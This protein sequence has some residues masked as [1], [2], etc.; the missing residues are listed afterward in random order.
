VTVLLGLLALLLGVWT[1][2]AVRLRRA[3]RAV[4][5]RIHVNG[6]RGK[7]SVTRLI[8]GGLQE[9]GIP[10]V[11]KTTGTRARFIQTDG[12]EVPVIR[13]GS[14]NICEQIDVLDRA[15]RAGARAV[16]VECMAIRPDLQ[17]VSEERILHSTLGVITNARPDHLDIMGP[18]QAD[19]AIALSSTIPRGGR[20]IVGRSPHRGILRRAA[21]ERCSTFVTADPERLPPGAMDGFTY[22]E[23]EENVATALAVTGSLGVPDE[24]ALRGMY[25]VTPDPG[26][27]TRWRLQHRGGSIEF[28]NI[29]AAN[30]LESTLSLWRRLGLGRAETPTIALLNLRGDR[31]DRSLQFADAVETGLRADYYFLV[32][33]FN[34]GVLRRFQGKAPPGRL[35]ALGRVP[36]GDIFDRISE[37][38]QSWRVGGVG[39]M[40]GLGHEILDFVARSGGGSC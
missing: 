26:A 11:A 38:G 29:F 14:P 17:A 18:T 1:L 20:L 30:D 23:H 39:N 34:E 27:C 36:A 35:R 31:L 5:I 33:D 28:V 10:T 7:S 12:S 6:S 25:R 15:R 22:V 19:V 37:L 8:V 13:M 40:G 24:T 16:V 4:P 21:A 9:A 32:G 3:L 2:E